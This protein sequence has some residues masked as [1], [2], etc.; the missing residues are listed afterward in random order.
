M[1]SSRCAVLPLAGM[2]VLAA[3]LLCADGAGYER[4]EIATD[5]V[6]LVY[7]DCVP[8]CEAT[9]GTFYSEV[10]SDMA[11]EMEITASRI[12]IA[13]VSSSAAGTYVYFTVAQQTDSTASERAPAEAISALSYRTT[14]VGGINLGGSTVSRYAPSAEGLP[15]THCVTL[16]ETCKAATANAESDVEACATTDLDGLAS[17]CTSAGACSYS[18]AIVNVTAQSDDTSRENDGNHDETEAHH[19]EPLG[20]AFAFL[21]ISLMLGTFVKTLLEQLP[22]SAYHP[23]Y[24]VMIFGLGMLCGQIDHSANEDG[25]FSITIHQSIDYWA[26]ID[27]H[28]IMYGLLPPLLFES[29]LN[30]DF[31]VFSKVLYVAGI[32]AL[33]GVLVST[34]LTGC[35]AM[36]FFGNCCSITWWSVVLLGSILSATDPVAVVAV[37]NTLGAPAHLQHMIEG[38]SLL[39]DGS[40]VVVFLIAEQMLNEDTEL[41]VPQMFGKFLRLAGGGVLWG[42][43]S[44][45][46]AFFWCKLS[47]HASVIDIAVLVLCIYVVFYLGEHYLHVSGVLASVTFGVLFCRLAPHAMSEH[48]EHANHVVFSQICH[49]AETHIFMLAGIIIHRRFF[50]AQSGLD[51]TYHVPMSIVLYLVLHIIRASVIGLFTP[52]L[53]R[54]GY[55]LTLGEGVIMTYGGLR[56]AVSLAMALMLDMNTTVDEDFR[57]LVVFHT[58]MVV[59]LTIVINGTTAGALYGWLDMYKANVFR[60]ELR[61]R[62]FAFLAQEVDTIFAALAHDWFHK[63]ADTATLRKVCP[64]FKKAKMHYGHIHV[65]GTHVKKIFFDKNGYVHEKLHHWKRAKLGMHALY[66]LKMHPA[67]ATPHASGLSALEM[68][69]ELAASHDGTGPVGRNHELRQT[70][71]SH[72]ERAT[73]APTMTSP[74]TSEDLR[75]PISFSSRTGSNHKD[76]LCPHLWVSG[77]PQYQASDLAVRDLFEPFGTVELIFLR[78]KPDSA[79][80][81]EPRSWAY[82]T[83]GGTGTQIQESVTKALLGPVTCKNEEGDTF[84]LTVQVAEQQKATSAAAINIW[85]QMKSNAARAKYSVPHSK[86][87]TSTTVEEA[88]MLLYE[89]CFT[90]V[91]ARY[92]EMEHHKLIGL[93]SLDR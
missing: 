28:V 9:L 27:P 60:K 8:S 55:G 92:Q 25:E 37:L 82:I 51:M 14:Q 17:S 62:G 80:T 1:T 30:M 40:A 79:S 10:R 19:G 45:Y 7:V 24:S 53:V 63:P 83:F 58:A 76:E 41:T 69:H 44:G 86:V 73:S 6:S 4:V 42:L 33:P 74:T 64:D 88:K 34:L 3:L 65:P 59:A 39:N 61:E 23:P 81:N 46:L 67:G 43:C 70:A 87:I 12:Q 54:L 66:Q 16:S 57:D 77:L 75:P 22:R 13:G 68:P 48:V 89:I 91:T 78:S 35:V 72:L 36:L 56:G 31:H 26:K 29:A 85:E 71:P 49:F 84:T 32:M 90:A 5:F 50:L 47:R 20:I 52:I 21:M 15:C 38:E 2:G 11:T 18:S 93:K